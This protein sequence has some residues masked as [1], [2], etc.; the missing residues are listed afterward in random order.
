M[1]YLDIGLLG[2]FLNT[3]TQIPHFFENISNLLTPFLTH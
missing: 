3:L 2:P 1:V